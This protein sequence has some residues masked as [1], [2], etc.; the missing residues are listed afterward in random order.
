MG[1][2]S[3]EAE[4]EDAIRHGDVQCVRNMIDRGADVDARDVHGRTA[5]MIAAHAGHRELVETLIAHR[6]DL[7]TTAKYRLSAVML[8]VVAGHAEVAWLLADAGAD[9]SLRGTGAPG[10]AGKTARDLAVERDMREL[11]IAL[12]SGL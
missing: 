1:P 12:K 6:A 2:G 3:M 4:W 11:S 7:N 9:R 10:F 5:L 8:A